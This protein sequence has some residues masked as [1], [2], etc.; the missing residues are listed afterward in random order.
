[1]SAS[2]IDTDRLIVVEELAERLVLAT[3][4]VL[5]L[6]SAGRIPCIKLNQRVYRFHWPTVLSQLSEGSIPLVSD[7]DRLITVEEVAERLVLTPGTVLE[8][9]GADTIPCIK[10]NRR[11]YRFH[12]PT[13]LDA[14]S[15]RH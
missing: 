9:V 5:E 4:T 2:V 8:M 1:M 3:G 13:V 14:L 10:L 6:V 11:V 7:T 12:W 15:Q